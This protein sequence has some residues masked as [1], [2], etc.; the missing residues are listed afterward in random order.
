[1]SKLMKEIETLHEA[2]LK[3]LESKKANDQ[4]TGGSE[5]SESLLLQVSELQER[6]NYVDKERGLLIQQKETVF[7]CT[8]LTKLTN[9]DYSVYF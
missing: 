9:N 5:G 2:K 7:E 6:L 8:P 3:E 1:V 4:W